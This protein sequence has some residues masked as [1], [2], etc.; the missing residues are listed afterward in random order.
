MLFI[1]PGNILKMENIIK[2][3]LHSFNWNKHLKLIANQIHY[4]HIG[5]KVGFLW[6]IGQRIEYKVILDILNDLKKHK[7]ISD[8]V[9]L[10]ILDDNYIIVNSRKLSDICNEPTSI[11]FIDCSENLKLPLLLNG[12]P[13]VILQKLKIQLNN[14]YNEYCEIVVDDVCVP[15]MFGI[16]IGY[17]VVYWY[18]TELSNEN[19]LSNIDLIIYQ[20]IQDEDVL[21]QSFSVPKMLHDVPQI[22][23]ALREWKM[24]VQNSNLYLKTF[25]ANL[26]KA[27]L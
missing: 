19:C 16:L 27:I 9:I 3:Y 6:D 23:N 10:F 25:I 20:S 12:I 17:P 2:K 4:V 8:D 18:N 21:I 7:Y 15:T 26:E 1:L 22:Q 24:K 14:T 11:A 5:F 13:N